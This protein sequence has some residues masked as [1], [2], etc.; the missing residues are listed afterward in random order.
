VARQPGATRELILDAARS[1]LL[2][3][4]YSGLSTR[5]VADGAAVPLS[6]VHYHFRGKQQLILSVLARENERL[7]ERQTQMY[8]QA[9]PLW[10]RYEQACD[11][12]DEDL[13][14]GYVRVLQ[15]MA[16][17]GWTNDGVA[18]E[19]RRLLQRWFDL[20]TEVLD[21]AEQQG[22]RL[23]PFRPREV[24]TLVGLQFMGAESMLLL[25]LEST[26]VPIR[27]ALR[28]VT[29]LIRQ[30]EQGEAS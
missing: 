17:A 22:L 23:G 27:P 19:V 14:S 7:V 15:E 18:V 25:G 29:E 3:E 1:G 28:R 21:E 24:A 11:F 16:A 26:H 10:E 12:L 30:M 8:G 5:K 6:Q 13:A 2:S 20:L 9:W 4:G